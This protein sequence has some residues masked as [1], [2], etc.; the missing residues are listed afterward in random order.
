MNIINFQMLP[1]IIIIFNQKPG[2]LNLKQLFNKVYV[3]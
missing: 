1:I 3:N 2:F